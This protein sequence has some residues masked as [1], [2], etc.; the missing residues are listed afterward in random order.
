M[1]RIA[2]VGAFDFRNLGDVLFID[3]LE[4]QLKKRIKDLEVVLFSPK[5]GILPHSNRT[6][7]PI[8]K[9]DAYH[10]SRPFDAIVVGGGD[11]LHLR[12]I[13]LAIDIDKDDE[14][15]EVFY[16]WVIPS[17]LGWKYGVPVVWNAPGAPLLFEDGQKHLVQALCSQVEY[18]SVRDENSK[19]VLKECGIQASKINV[20]PDTVL[21]INYCFKESELQDLFAIYEPLVSSKKY[22]F[23]QCNTTYTHE[24]LEEIAD[25]LKLVSSVTGLKVVLQEIGA[26]LRDKNS[27]KYI[28]ERYPQDF[29]LFDFEYDQYHIMSLIANSS[30][31][32]G[33]SLHGYILSCAFGV[34]AYILNKNRFSK[35]EGLT[36]SLGRD[37]D[38]ISCVD[39]LDI[40]A[41]QV[42]VKE[43]QV[44]PV[45]RDSIVKINSHFDTLAEIIESGAISSIEESDFPICLAEYF[46]SMGEI[47]RGFILRTEETF[48][49]SNKLDIA[50]QQLRIL[51]LQKKDLENELDAIKKSRSWVITS[52]LR[53]LNRL[54]K[55]K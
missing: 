43:H 18:I 4:R 37:C 36:K 41:R 48:H 8:S 16:M 23:F 21:S 38:V 32:I 26:G 13:S 7:F 39:D 51:E 31:Y 27:L 50:Q 42:D 17:L 14:L 54:L 55:I 24:E 45:L 11:L 5:G 20:V 25:T 3:V 35:I 12:K 53:K 40:I 10:Q 19:E 44:T 9:M 30:F 29:L 28:Y 15:Y 46:C 47:E 22:I 52:P 1:K 49:F 33:S 34:P 6:V 2:H